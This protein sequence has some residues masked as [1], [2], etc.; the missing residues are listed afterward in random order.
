MRFF[1]SV[2]FEITDKCNLNCVFCYEKYRRKNKDIDLEVFKKA[3][4]KYKPL[5][6]R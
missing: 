2:I 5:L 4:Y 3:I 6:K 1:P